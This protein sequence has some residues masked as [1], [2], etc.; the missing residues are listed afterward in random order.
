MFKNG[1]KSYGVLYDKNNNFK[2]YEG[3]FDSDGCFFDGTVIKFIE[4]NTLEV[5]TDRDGHKLLVYTD[6]EGNKH[7]GSYDEGDYIN[8]TV[9]AP[10]KNDQEPP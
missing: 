5:K 8:F 7:I 6:K 1:L 10:I 2:L 4:G 3:H 9:D